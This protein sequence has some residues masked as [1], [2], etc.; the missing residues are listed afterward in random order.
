LQTGRLD[1]QTFHASRPNQDH[2]KVG[3]GFNL[4]DK[5]DWFQDM[6]WSVQ[7]ATVQS[8]LTNRHNILAFLELKPC[9]DGRPV[10]ALDTSILD[11]ALECLYQEAIGDIQLGK[12][13]I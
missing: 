8:I 4:Q 3:L 10:L 5:N 1:L 13:K 12:F 11:H 9:T 7:Q 2:L 6:G